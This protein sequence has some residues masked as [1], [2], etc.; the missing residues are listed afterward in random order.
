M[1]SRNNVEESA[2]LNVK[3]FTKQLIADR[4]SVLI[5]NGN[6]LPE[7]VLNMVKRAHQQYKEAPSDQTFNNI[8]ELISQTKYVE[9]SVEYKNFNRGIF[10]LATTLIVKKMK[11]VFPNYGMFFANA[12]K[13]L[14]KINPDMRHSAKAM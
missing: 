7:S 4:C 12:S 2:P 10:L 6:L 5:E 9:E 11:D 13:K 14:E 8:K 1:A 3:D